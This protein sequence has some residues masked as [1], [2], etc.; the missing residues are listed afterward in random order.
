MGSTEPTKFYEIDAPALHDSIVRAD[1]EE[2]LYYYVKGMGRFYFDDVAT[3]PLRSG[4]GVRVEFRSFERPFSLGVVLRAALLYRFASEAYP[5][6]P[7]EERDIV[8]W[9]REYYE[10]SEAK[11]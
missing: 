2:R 10:R 8:R 6:F 11:L 9:W 3:G 1:D 5:D 7:D 4:R